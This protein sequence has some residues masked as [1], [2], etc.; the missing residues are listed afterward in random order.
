MNLPFKKQTYLLHVGK[1]LNRILQT[2]T[3]IIVVRPFS[4]QKIPVE[5]KKKTQIVLDRKW[6]RFGGLEDIAN[7]RFFGY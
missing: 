4:S 2:L 3:R 7:W 1:I 5:M 6:P